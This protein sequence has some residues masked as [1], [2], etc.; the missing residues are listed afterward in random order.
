MATGVLNLKTVILAIH[1]S[2]YNN[3]LHCLEAFWWLQ[4]NSLGAAPGGLSLSRQ[5]INVMGLVHNAAPPLGGL[6]Q[7]CRMDSAENDLR[8][9]WLN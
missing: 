7:P 8:E 3:P 5:Q 6:I 9:R 2:R 4:E 1:V